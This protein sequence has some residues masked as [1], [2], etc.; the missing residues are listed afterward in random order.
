M[1]SI[2]LETLEFVLPTFWDDEYGGFYIAVDMMG[3]IQTTDKYAIPQALGVEV[4]L[5]M[6]EVNLPAVT[7]LNWNPNAPTPFDQIK[8]SVSTF[9][10]SS[11][12]TIVLKYS[13]DDNETINTIPL[14]AHSYIADVYEAKIGPFPNGTSLNAFVWANNSNGEEFS[15]ITNKIL[16]SEDKT[17]PEVNLIGTN[18]STPMAGELVIITAHSVDDRPQVDVEQVTITYREN[19]NEW[20]TQEL[21]PIGDNLYNVTIGP[22]S[23]ESTIEY[24]FTGSDTFGNSLMTAV[25]RITIAPE[26]RTISGFEWVFTLFALTSLFSLRYYVSRQKKHE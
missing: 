2:A 13:I 10:Q 26:Q 23:S 1:Y 4:L 22:F 18:P 12:E 5:K 3:E 16:V 11:I 19:Q 15:G 8:F 6:Q 9:G 21:D 24:Y 7:N 14:D 17:G 20:V 25:W